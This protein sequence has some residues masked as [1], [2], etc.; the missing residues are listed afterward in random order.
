MRERGL[1]LRSLAFYTRVPVPA[2]WFPSEKELREEEEGNP[3][4]YFPLI[5]IGVGGACAVTTALSLLL[6]EPPVAVLLGMISAVAITGAM[7]EDG[8]ADVCDGFGGGRD[9]EGILRI[10]KDSFIG[11][12]GVTGLTL[13]LLLKYTALLQ[14][15]PGNLPETWIAGHSLSRLAAISLLRF[16]PYASETTESK[17]GAMVLMTKKD[18]LPVTFFGLTPLLFI[19]QAIL[20]ALI[21][22]G[23]GWWIMKRFFAKRLDGVTGD[24]MG[25]TQQVTE[26][27]FYLGL[28]LNVG[29]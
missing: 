14:I 8:F 16:L 12:F 11:A 24:C 3:S 25:A 5:G 10:M 15:S 7:H 23:V 18:W 21:G 6:W 2:R 28:G 27:V 26:T 4:R 22:A 1:L 13:M 17:S 9:A 20:L 29:I 19:G